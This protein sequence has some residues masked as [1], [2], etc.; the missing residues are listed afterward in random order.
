[1]LALVVL[2]VVVVAAAAVAVV[3]IFKKGNGERPE[4]AAR[5]YLAAWSRQDWPGMAALVDQPP[6]T[7]STAHQAEVK[8]LGLISASY[9]L[10]TVSQHGSSAT[11]AYTAHVM[12]QGLGAWDRSAALPLHR[13]GSHWR[14]QWTPAVIYPGLSETTH[15][16]RDRTWPARANILGAGGVV[17]TPNQSIVDIGVVGERIKDMA[18]LTGALTAAGANPAAVN[19][20]LAQAAAHPN[21]FVSVMTVPDD[22]NY[23][24]TIRPALYNLPG[25]QFVRRTAR[26]ALTPDLSAHVIGS[27]GSITAEQLKALGQLY[28]ATDRVGQTGL[29]NA[30]EGQLAGSPGGDVRVVDSSGHTVSTALT[31]PPKP[32]TDVHTSI[33]PHVELAAEGALTGVVQPA[34]LVAVKASTG[35]VLAAVSRP[36]LTPFNRALA[37]QYPPGSTFKVITAADLLASGLNPDSPATCPPT[38]TVGGRQFHNFEGETQPNLP[39]RQAFAVSCNTAFIGLAGSLTPQSLVSTAAQFGFGTDLKMGLPASGGRVPL[40]STDVEK[41]ATAIGQAQVQASPL[42]MASVAAAVAAGAYHAPRLVSGAPDDS[43]TPA[44]LNPSVATGLRQMMAEVVSN[45][46]G[47]PA[48]VPG[49]PQVSGKT[50]TAE[51]GSA[52]PPTTH[53]WFIGFQGDVAFAVLVEGG[54][55][56][57]SVAAPLAAKFVGGL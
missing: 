15:F 55:V 4:A 7:F 34:A 2:G 32:G 49:K 6:A 40:P 9:A 18:V 33:D 38:I 23:A 56:G 3:V 43:A 11:A 51:F 1:V 22:A 37:G 47:V 29:E 53:A 36:T 31:V 44:P 5:P 54:G 52:N 46:T 8:N 17:L 16:A 20:A 21:Q 24:Q 45:G 19:S 25:T 50:G 13:S 39:F 30:Y 26:Q 57:G 27:L 12:L 14:V 28:Q 35:E 42:Q 10:T 41:A 48:A